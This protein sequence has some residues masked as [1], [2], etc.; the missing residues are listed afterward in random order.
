MWA[1]KQKGEA[2]TWEVQRDR[3]VAPQAAT[4][5]AQEQKTF[6]AEDLRL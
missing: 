2:A 3:S 1:N 6:D 4:Q 5:G